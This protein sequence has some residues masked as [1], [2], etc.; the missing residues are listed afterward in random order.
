MNALPLCRLYLNHCFVAIAY[1]SYVVNEVWHLLIMFVMC[2]VSFLCV[3]WKRFSDTWEENFY[4]AG[5]W[6]ILHIVLHRN[7]TDY[8][9]PSECP[10]GRSSANGKRVSYAQLSDRRSSNFTW[11]L[12]K[13]RKTFGHSARESFRSTLPHIKTKH[14]GENI[15]C[16]ENVLHATSQSSHSYSIFVRDIRTKL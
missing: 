16:T 7:G 10:M 1:V 6:W 3:W 15:A 4:K 5:K 8:S 12:A 9:G 2:D 13:Y 11:K 14:F